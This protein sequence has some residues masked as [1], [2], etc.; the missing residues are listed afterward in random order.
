M[1]VSSP[2][3]ESNIPSLSSSTSVSSGIPSLSLSPTTVTVTAHVVSLSPH[4][5][6]GVLA[7]A[8]YWYPVKALTIFSITKVSPFDSLNV[9]RDVP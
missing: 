5:K 2:S 7:I 9:G 6:P 4:T 8:L 3:T 1:S